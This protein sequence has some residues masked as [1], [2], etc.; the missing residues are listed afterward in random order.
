MTND[1][2]ER[3]ES[4]CAD[5]EGCYADHHINAIREAISALSKPVAW[6]VRWADGE[7]ELTEDAE[8][9]EE[10]RIAK[11]QSG[12]Q[13][14]ITPLAALTTTEGGTHGSR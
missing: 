11:E 8:R 14:T 12:A 5:F 3:L 7:V 2:I 10:Y 9:V 13:L 1:L 4:A 6:R